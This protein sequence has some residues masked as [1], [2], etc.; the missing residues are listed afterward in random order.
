VRIGIAQLDCWAGE[1]QTNCGK[2]RSMA[3]RAADAGCNLLV[4]PEYSDIGGNSQA[5]QE[6]ATDWDGPHFEFLKQT[7]AKTGVTL[8]CGLSERCENECFNTLAVINR[9]GELTARY[10]KIH[11]FATAPFHEDKHV[12]SGDEIVLVDVDGLLIGLMICYD[13]RFPEM[14]RALALKGAQLLV[15]P[16]AW[17]H[18]RQDHWR[19]LT[20]CRAVENQLYVAAANMVGDHGSVT[21]CG[22]SALI[23]PLGTAKCCGSGTREELIIGDIDPSFIEETRAGIRVFDDR[24]PEVYGMKV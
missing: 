14:A 6:H 12:G 22:H 18:P 7:A 23:D 16:A 1:V 8:M 11:L 5:I 3:Q 4:T 13:V 15:I 24:K 21:F 20:K 10:R 17:P 19:L 9:A 2:I